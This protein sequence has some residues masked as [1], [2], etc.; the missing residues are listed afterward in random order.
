VKKTKVIVVEKQRKNSVAT[1]GISPAAPN[2]VINGY[3]LEVVSDFVYLGSKESKTGD[4]DAE[5]N[6]RVQRMH[7][8]FE[9]WSGRILLNPCLSKRLQLTFFNLIVVSNGVYG[10]ATWNLTAKHMG[11]LDSAQFQLLKRL[12]KVRP[13][14]NIS[15]ET[16]LR[17]TERDGCAILPIECKIGKLQ[18]RY[19]GHVERMGNGRLQKQIMY[20]CLDAG[21]RNNRIGAPSQNYRLVIVDAL[22]KFGYSPRSWRDDAGDRSSWRHHLNSQGQDSCIEKWLEKKAA[23]RLVRHARRDRLVVE[24]EKTEDSNVEYYEDG[25]DNEVGSVY[26]F[27]SEG[28]DDEQRGERI[29]AR[30]VEVGEPVVEHRVAP[31]IVVQPPSLVV[32][33]G[34]IVIP[35]VAARKRRYQGEARRRRIAAMA[36]DEVAHTISIDCGRPRMGLADDNTVLSRPQGFP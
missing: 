26:S 12:F 27:R 14:S 8:A 32:G 35:M 4:L 28:Y 3:V 19:L 9:E 15:Y 11:K 30:P 36:R 6:V 10:C 16:I 20:S 7:A 1:D 31:T 17:M 23:Q 29:I 5:V 13:A 21:G 18:L 25:S 2:I 33:G 34:D 24:E 22:K